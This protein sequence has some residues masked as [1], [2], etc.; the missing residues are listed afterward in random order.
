VLRGNIMKKKLMTFIILITTIFPLLFGSAQ[1]S[2]SKIIF[3][4]LLG[5]TLSTRYMGELSSH[6][7]FL[8]SVTSYSLIPWGLKILKLLPNGMQNEV[9]SDESVGSLG[10]NIGSL[11]SR[12]P[13][14]PKYINV[15]I[16]ADEYGP[17]EYSLK[18]YRG[19][20]TIGVSGF[21]F[22]VGSFA[23]NEWYLL[24]EKFSDGQL[25]S[26]GEQWSIENA[27]ENTAGRSTE[28]VTVNVTEVRDYRSIRSESTSKNLTEDATKV[29]LPQPHGSYKGIRMPIRRSQLPTENVTVNDTEVRGYRSIRSQL[30]TENVTV[31]DTEV[32]GYRSIR[33]QLD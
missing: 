1:S 10:E 4:E 32:R 12:N 30:P 16:S 6:E 26:E 11:I 22:N 18:L 20:M 29:E 8:I 5:T 31:N 21:Q 2:S 25:K 19:D 33:S 17:G 9:F 28:N 14:K 3:D 13:S 7:S 24:V 23:P 15:S 27:L